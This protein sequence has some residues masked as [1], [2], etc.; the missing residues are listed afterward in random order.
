MNILIAEDDP[1]NLMLVRGILEPL[2][3]QLTTARDGGEAQN[4]MAQVTFDLF[5]FDIMMPVATGLELCHQCRH[6]PR[7]RDVPILLLTALASKDDLIRGFK[8]GA[9]DYVAKPFHP[10][11]LLYRVKAHLKMRTLQL[12][13]DDAV[14]RASLQMLELDRKQQELESKERE[15]SE[16]NDLLSAANKTLLEMASR[17]PL[18]GLLNR[19]KGWDFL[20]Y[21][22]ERSER[23]KRP[24]CLALL[25][26]DKFKSVNDNLGHETGDVVLKAAAG[27]LQA[28]VRASDI[29]IRWG[30]EEFLIAFP[31]TDLQGG[32]QAAEKIR[33]AFEAHP[34]PLPDGRTMTVSIG[35]TEKLPGQSWDHAIDHADRG[36]YSAKESGRNRIATLSLT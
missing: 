10:T 9:T 34:W 8:A 27:I 20:N 23:T 25:D 7:H 31:E 22:E 2:G 29:V 32:L 17:D 12:M 6:D 21:E 13:M 3:H 30:G 11:E 4:L 19:R 24:I 35:V 36:L 18:T 33:A 14:N 26:L 1:I 16:M 28:T 15:L 5:L